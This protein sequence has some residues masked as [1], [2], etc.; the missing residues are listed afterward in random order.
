MITSLSAIEV[1]HLTKTYGNLKAV[2][3]LSFQVEP[4]SVFAFLGTNG[5]GK[6]TTINCIT[7]ILDYDRGNIS[8]NGQQLGEDNAKIRRQIGVVF[9]SS[10]LDPLLTVKENLQVRVGLYG[11]SAREASLRIAELIDHIGLNTFI[12]QR[13]GKLS[14]GQRRR[15]DIARSLLHQPSILFLDEP[16]TSLDPQSRKQ[17]WDTIRTLRES[18]GITVLLTTHYMAETEEA[19]EVLIIDAGKTVAQGTPSEL[20]AT[21]GQNVLMITT[22]SPKKLQALCR[23]LRLHHTL[24]N[25][26]VEIKVDS[27]TQALKIL[28]EHSDSV[29]DFEFRHGSMDDVFL[30][31]TQKKKV[32]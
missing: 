23:S 15:V 16:T 1:K 27:A 6:S 5:A 30:A 28:K 10:L 12:N 24:E 3:D 26:I 4:K 32:Q 7:T 29:R 17:V 11:L 19:D 2:E 25:N 9:Q 22:D 31:L 13:Y 14:G 18:R 20:R 21:Y 8:V